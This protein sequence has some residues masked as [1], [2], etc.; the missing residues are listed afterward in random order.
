MKKR[1]KRYFISLLRTLLL[2][3]AVFNLTVSCN[4]KIKAGIAQSTVVTR[5]ESFKI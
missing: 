5:C 2:L 3:S 1:H 4:C